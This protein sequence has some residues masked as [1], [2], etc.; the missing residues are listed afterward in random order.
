MSL[1]DKIRAE[2]IDIRKPKPALI[3]RPDRIIN[4]LQVRL[5][6]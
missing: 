3:L 1:A 6:P 2:H 5:I 4:S